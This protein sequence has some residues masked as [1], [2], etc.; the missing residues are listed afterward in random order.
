MTFKPFI[1]PTPPVTCGRFR[2]SAATTGFGRANESGLGQKAYALLEKYG[3]MPAPELLA[4]LVLTRPYTNLTLLAL[5]RVLYR[6]SD[7]VAL[8]GEAWR[9]AS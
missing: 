2:S 7:L 1:K 8:D 5:Q 4:R 6:R 3:P 9:T